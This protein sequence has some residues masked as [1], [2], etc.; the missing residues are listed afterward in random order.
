MFVQTS[1]TLQSLFTP[2]SFLSFFPLCPLSSVLN[3]SC[4]LHLSH[5]SY[6]S[7][8]LYHA[9]H[10]FRLVPLALFLFY[11]SHTSCT[12]PA[13]INEWKRVATR[14]ALI[15]AL[16]LPPRSRRSPIICRVEQLWKA[17][18]GKGSA[19][20]SHKIYLQ[21]FVLPEKSGLSIIFLKNAFV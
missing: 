16:L 20:P 15:N 11:F 14:P 10:T 3:A 4:T 5:S 7:R 19:M 9:P 13:V 12:V 21:L 6:A 17:H 18:L 2:P 1:I 8:T